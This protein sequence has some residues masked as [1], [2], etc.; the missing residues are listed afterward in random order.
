[1]LLA[2]REQNGPGRALVAADVRALPLR[3]GAF[4]LIW[5]RL[6][7]G[8]L[9]ELDGV[10]G[11]LARVSRRDSLLI[12]SDFH[13]A[14][15]AAGHTRTFRDASGQLRTIVHHVHGPDDHRRAALTAGWSLDRVLD[16]APGPAER[17]IYE[18][19]GRAEQFDQEQ[20][21]ELPLVLVMCL[22]R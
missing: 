3:A 9:P 1:M 17:T 4:D 19:A 2:G 10:Y 5:C 20:E 21:Q 13:P 7:V 18:R 6:V 14:A 15:V 11:E 12:V 8:H 16:A 22:G